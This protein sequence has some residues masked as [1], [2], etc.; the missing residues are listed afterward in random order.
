MEKIVMSSLYG[1][2]VDTDS[3]E[4]K[5]VNLTKEEMLDEMRIMLEIQ[6]ENGN[7]NYDEYMH[8]M[9]NGMEFMLARFEGREP[10]YRSKPEKWLSAG[11]IRN[12]LEKELKVAKQYGMDDF[13]VGLTHAK[14]LSER[15]GK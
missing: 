14:I 10:V 1:K 13:I 2:Y 11:H 7:W 9:Y 12:V 8:G 3:L 15:N 5:R 6:G 4:E